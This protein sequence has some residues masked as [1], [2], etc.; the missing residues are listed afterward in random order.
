MTSTLLAFQV[1][2]NTSTISANSSSNDTQLVIEQSGRTPG[3]FYVYN[4]SDAVTFVNITTDATANVV[5][6]TGNQDG[7][8]FPV[9]RYNP[10]IINLNQGYNYTGGNI[11]I[12]AVCPGAES[13]IYF[14]PIA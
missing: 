3:A 14:T 8:G 7:R 6:A 5:V 13:D 2:G 12:T 10:V 1:N 11:Y 9:F 4:S